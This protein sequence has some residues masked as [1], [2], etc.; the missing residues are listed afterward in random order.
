M[1]S[2][3]ESNSDSS[4]GSRKSPQ[5]S[6]KSP[7]ENFEPPQGSP[8]SPQ[9]SIM[10]PQENFEPSQGSIS[11]FKSVSLERKS[12]IYV[13]PCLQEEAWGRRYLGKIGVGVE[14]ECG[15]LY[16]FRASL[17][18]NEDREE[19]RNKQSLKAI[20]S[21][22]VGNMTGINPQY[23][24]RDFVPKKI[25]KLEFVSRWCEGNLNCS[26]DLKKYKG[27]DKSFD[28]ILTKNELLTIPPCL[29]TYDCKTKSANR[30]QHWKDLL[31][32]LF[33]LQKF[34]NNKVALMVSHT[35]RMVG[36]LMPHDSCNYYNNCACIKITISVN[37]DTI[38]TLKTIIYQGKTT[39]KGVYSCEYPEEEDEEL[40]NVVS[41][42]NIEG[43]YYVIYLVRHGNGL[44]NRPLKKKTI[45]SCLT[46]LGVDQAFKLG[47]FLSGPD[48]LNNMSMENIVVCS[49]FLR[50]TQHTALAVLKGYDREMFKNIEKF[51]KGLI[52][53]NVE[54]IMRCYA[55]LNLPGGLG[56]ETP[57]EILQNK[58][59][60]ILLKMGLK[61]VR[62]EEEKF[63]SYCDL[64]GIP[65]PIRYGTAGK[66]NLKKKTKR[67]KN[68]SRG[69]KPSVGKKPNKKTKRN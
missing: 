51:R 69:R 53:F 37:N 57:V 30:K 10:P 19:P 38:K 54:T 28:S 44:H 63:S 5:R 55:A 17:T 41:G 6:R 49:S 66:K 47:E 67:G 24:E 33:G 32:F 20:P 62:T 34:K 40:N 61:K 3:N 11:D 29:E 59:Q 25:D 18:G 9:R 21:G 7:Q 36:S 35:N 60:I 64:F 65:I 16:K 48:Q 46:P 27:K 31:R 26:K 13:L 1:S 2:N 56:G 39:K 4:M 45:D 50:R 8:K 14:N 52:N 43:G 42:L 68:S 15:V 12:Q 22:Y 58:L 23:E